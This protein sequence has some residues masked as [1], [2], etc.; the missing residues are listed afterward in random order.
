MTLKAVHHVQVTY[1][2]E[3]EEAMQFF[4]NQVL[5]LT[6]IPRPEALNHDGGAWYILGDIQV[7]LSQEKSANEQ[8]SRR[9]ICFQVDNLTFFEKHLQAYHIEIIPDQRP[10]PGYTRFF[11]RDPGGN[12]IEITQVQPE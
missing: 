12:R 2:P 5:G 4:Y 10:I 1:S 7:H 11:L 8:L 6:E 9:H 3:V